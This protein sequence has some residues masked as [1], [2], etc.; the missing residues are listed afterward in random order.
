MA[1]ARAERSGLRQCVATAA[2][3][4]SLDITHQLADRLRCGTVAARS[5]S[6]S[7]IGRTFEDVTSRGAR[8]A[9]TL[10]GKRLHAF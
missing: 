7:A 1:C 3:K 10:S 8:D 2:A 5:K 6:K 9:R 4:V